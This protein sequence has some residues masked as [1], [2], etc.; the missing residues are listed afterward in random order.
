MDV[1]ATFPQ[2][3]ILGP[4]NIAIFIAMFY[5]II[6]NVDKVS[7]KVRSV[8]ISISLALVFSF[9]WGLN[10]M[11]RDTGFMQQDYSS[12][13]SKIFAT[14]FAIFMLLSV[15]KL[16]KIHNGDA[17]TSIKKRKG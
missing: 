2:A 14:L 13:I 12:L 9:L 11:A 3:F 5:M 16:S 8:L 17:K 1:S 10:S 15:Y 6:R 7:P 4:L